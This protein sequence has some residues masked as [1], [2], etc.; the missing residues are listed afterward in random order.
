MFKDKGL[1]IGIIVTIVLIGGGVILMSRGSSGS[2]SSSSSSPVSSNIL[3][4]NGDYETSGIENGNYLP[5]SASAKV[6]LVEFGD[7]ECPACGEYHPF[8]TQLLTDEAGKVNFVFRNFPL[9]Q[10][11]NAQI[12]AQA[13]EA[14]GLQ[15]KF[16]QMH[17][18]IYLSQ[19]DWATLSDP[20]SIFVGYAK[21]LGLDVNKFTSDLSSD[22]VKN[23]ISS[24]TNDGNLV[25]INETPT[26]FINGV[27]IDNL[28][29][30]YSDFKSLVSAELNK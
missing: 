15:G 20:T 25:N 10:H 24:D 2:S 27:K 8:V 11:P 4:P 12:S 6:T 1:I 18:K 3:I 14:V 26:F 21:N 29:G 17:D 28:P 23:K 16:W 9:S 22:A 19:N 7:Y 5:A 13:A 30:S